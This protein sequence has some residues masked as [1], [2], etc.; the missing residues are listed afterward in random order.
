MPW[1]GSYLSSLCKGGIG[2]SIWIMVF[3]VGFV[4]GCYHYA[5][6]QFRRDFSYVLSNHLEAAEGTLAYD[7]GIIKNGLLQSR[8][9]AF[10]FPGEPDWMDVSKSADTF[11]GTLDARIVMRPQPGVTNRLAFKTVPNGKT[12]RLFYG[13]SDTARD[14]APATGLGVSLK[15]IGG[16]RDILHEKIITWRPTEP[17]TGGLRS[18][19]LPF[20][21]IDQLKARRTLTFEVRM[22]AD[23]NW[24]H[25]FYVDGYIW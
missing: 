10:R 12:L 1:K 15:V 14:S 16:D 6:H 17:W 2:R 8:G 18:V 9:L 4:W 25:F 24:N 20:D 5:N 3:A 13:F 23:L 22:A 21:S 11:N 7:N 19:D